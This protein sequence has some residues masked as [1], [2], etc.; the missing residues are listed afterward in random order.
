MYGV[1]PA[2]SVSVPVEVDLY[3]DSA[4]TI[5]V[6]GKGW[7]EILVLDDRAA[8]SAMGASNNTLC[9]IGHGRADLFFPASA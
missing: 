4:A 9:G 6:A 8:T 1:A 7:R 2:G 3:P 5:N